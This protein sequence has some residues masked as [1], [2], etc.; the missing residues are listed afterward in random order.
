V[1]TDGFLIKRKNEE[2]SVFTFDQ[3]DGAGLFSDAIFKVASRLLFN[4]NLL[5]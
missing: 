4:F 3:N 1:Q 5:F 2:K